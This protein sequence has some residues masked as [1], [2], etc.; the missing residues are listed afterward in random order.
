MHL[1]YPNF[2]FSFART[3]EISLIDA[4]KTWSA[5]SKNLCDSEREM[6]ENGGSKSGER[7]AIFY[8]TWCSLNK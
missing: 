4:E 5:F 1:Q 8:S 3:L 6:I 7:E 2:I